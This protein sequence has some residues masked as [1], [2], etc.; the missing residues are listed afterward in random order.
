[1]VI[2]WTIPFRID[3]VL[4]WIFW[5][6]I[7]IKVFWSGVWVSQ[8]A[9]RVKNPPAVQEM[10][11]QFLGQEDPLE[12]GMATHSSILAWRIPMDRGVWQATVHRVA[13]NQT[14]LKYLSTHAPTEWGFPL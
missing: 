13:K 4:V 1:M 7:R 12:E 10:W 8:V 2:S 11:V 14:G 5:C 3:S 9:Q 6:S